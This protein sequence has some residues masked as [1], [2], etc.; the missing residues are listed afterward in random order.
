MSEAV[1]RFVGDAQA[2]FYEV[3]LSSHSCPSCGGRLAMTGESRCRCETCG[4]E[5]DPTCAFQRCPACGGTPRLRVRRYECETCGTDV[6][7][8][9]V[10]NGLV[11]DVEYFRQKMEEHRQGTGERLERVREMLA[12]S[13]SPA[14]ATGPLDLRSAPGLIDALNALPGGA[15]AA[16]PIETRSRFDLK[17]YQTHVQAN[18]G[19]FARGFD[20]IPALR[21]DDR[22]DRVWRF[23]AIIF[24]AHEGRVEVVQEGEEIMVMQRETDR[25]GQDISGELEE[26]DGVEG[27]VG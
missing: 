19:P 13:R 22:L 24:L 7:S 23:I 12:A 3:A 5:S 10:F 2:F 1:E 27:L 14:L 9:F 21:S 26:A 15:P 6:P 4:Q 17:A 18:L 16:L 20:E 11:F 8:R 25:E